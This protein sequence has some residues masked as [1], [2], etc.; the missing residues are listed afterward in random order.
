MIKLLSTICFTRMILSQIILYCLLLSYYNSGSFGFGCYAYSS[1][2]LHSQRVN[3]KG[4]HCNV[5][6]SLRQRMHHQQRRNAYE[7]PPTVSLSLSLSLSPSTICWRRRQTSLLLA[8]PIDDDDDGE[9]ESSSNNNKKKKMWGKFFNKKK[10]PVDEKPVEEDGDGEIDQD[11]QP[12]MGEPSSSSSSVED[13]GDYDGGKL[14]DEDKKEFNEDE[15][16]EKDTDDISIQQSKSANDD[17][18]QLENALKLIQQKNPPSPD[19]VSYNNNL[20]STNDLGNDP[21]KNSKDSDQGDDYG[22][23]VQ[24]DD[25]TAAKTPRTDNKTETTTLSKDDDDKPYRRRFWIF[26]RRKANNKNRTKNT[27][28]GSIQTTK[29]SSRNKSKENKAKNKKTK[30]KKKPSVSFKNASELVVAIPEPTTSTSSKT[31]DDDLVNKPPKKKKKNGVLGKA[32][33]TFVLI[34][35]IMLYPMVADEV[36]DRITVRTS[37]VPRMRSSENNNVEPNNNDDS[38]TIPPSENESSDKSTTVHKSDGLKENKDDDAWKDKIPHIPKQRRSFTVP[39]VPSSNGNINN[40]KN[41]PNPLNLRDKRRLALSFISDVVDQ[42]GPSVVRIDTENHPAKGPSTKGDNNYSPPGS[43]IQ[44]GQGSGLIFSSEGFILTNAHV[45]EGATKVKGKK[46]VIR[47][48]MFMLLLLLFLLLL[49]L[50]L[51]RVICIHGIS[52]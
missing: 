39:P 27:K 10:N 5:I 16:D 33:R 31:A 52:I 15:D 46:K 9:E 4:V 28:N 41:I 35:T 2:L 47:K 11:D 22:D 17:F 45:V 36:G 44:Q 21:Q 18:T 29:A 40:N 19:D 7:Y 23:L 42:V 50:L 14:D 24:M 34:A 48:F 43:Y 1:I 49:L 37:S 8:G 30:N 26:G 51:L 6:S 12:T 20:T 25:A 13:E 38:T 3:N 32:F